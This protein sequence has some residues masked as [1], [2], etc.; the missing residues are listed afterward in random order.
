M[1]RPDC[2]AT[3]NEWSRNRYRNM[4]CTGHRKENREV[5]RNVGNQKAGE[6]VRHILKT[7]SDE[8]MKEFF[9]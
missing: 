3:L 1:E 5:V 2:T 4:C 7:E 8:P 6:Q 9:W